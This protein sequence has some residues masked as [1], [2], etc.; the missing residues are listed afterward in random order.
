MGSLKH[1]ADRL[2]VNRLGLD[3]ARNAAKKDVKEVQ[4]EPNGPTDLGAPKFGKEDPNNEEHSG[5]NTW[6]GGVRP[7]SF[8]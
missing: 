6:A 2:K 1:S 4:F 3:S 7:A 5:G 8:P